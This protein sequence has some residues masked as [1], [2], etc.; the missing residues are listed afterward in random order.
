MY[1]FVAEAGTVD[2]FVVGDVPGAWKSAPAQ[3]FT[4]ISLE[5]I[6]SEIT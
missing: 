5:A 4:R 2:F 6:G 1:K 3:L